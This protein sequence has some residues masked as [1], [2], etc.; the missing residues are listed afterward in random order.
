MLRGFLK[1]IAALIALAIVAAAVVLGLAAN[2]RTVD[3]ARDIGA[4]AKDPAF[5][6]RGRYLAVA[7][8]CAACHT[9]EGG[10]EFAGGL[11]LKT[12]FGTIYAT[13]ITPDT[14]TGIGG[15]TAGRF[16]AAMVE[17]GAFW[18]PLYPAM[19]Y[20]SYHLVTRDDLDALYAYFMSLKPVD[21][22]AKPNA[23][24]FPFGI[25]LLLQGWNLLFLDR[26]PFQPSPA[27][28]EIWNR[29]AYLAEGLGH[30]GE[31]HTPR[32]RLGEMLA[33]DALAGA[34]IDGMDAPD[35]RPATLKAVGW[36]RENLV[37][38]FQSGA[39]PKGS[40]FGEMFVAIKDS[41]RHLSVDDQAALAV[42]LLDERGDEPGKGETAVAAAPPSGGDAKGAAVYLTY[43]GLCHGMA[44]Q[45]LPNV[46]PPLRGSATVAEPDGVN[47]VGTIARGIGPE[48]LSLTDAFGPMPAFAGR[49]G[50]EDMTALVNYLRA[51]F[52]PP[53]VALTPL[54]VAEVQRTAG[55]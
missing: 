35:I 52:A 55:E 28:S 7:G 1:W 22:P 48:R 25:R 12:P 3:R 32:G 38:F 26:G 45:G 30:C 44:G 50:A 49:I 31:C 8:D 10:V 9:A 21:A 15:W 17:G 19:P 54:T 6:E 14:K 27:K 51:A 20:T 11:P 33:G 37:T 23:L 47:L 4:K 39:G 13:N 40:A 24:A 36:T 5:I 34:V 43:C 29:G 53:G 42:Y 16:E 2:A 41:L 18:H 46:F